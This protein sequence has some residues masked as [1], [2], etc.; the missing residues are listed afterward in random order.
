MQRI[1]R[2]PV[3]PPNRQSGPRTRRVGLRNHPFGPRNRPASP[4]NRLVGLCDGPG[5]NRTRNR[6]ATPAPK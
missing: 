6:L 4:L 3:G 1:P 5:L 2:R